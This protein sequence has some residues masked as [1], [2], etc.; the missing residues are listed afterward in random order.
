MTDNELKHL[1]RAELIDIIYELQKE[2]DEKDA[3]MQKM[4]AALD[5]K[6]LRVAKAGSIAEAAI[7]VNGVFEA[8]QAA[9]EQYLTSVRAAEASNAERQAEA[10]R[11][12]QKLLEEANRKADEIQ[13]QAQ[14]QAQRIVREAEMQVAAKWTIF[15]QQAKNALLQANGELQ[16]MLRENG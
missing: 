3:Q 15:E 8:A 1:N 16:S 13:Q 12:R 5:E 10:E 14:R 11:Q 2:N 7:S 9:A 4:Q 6:T